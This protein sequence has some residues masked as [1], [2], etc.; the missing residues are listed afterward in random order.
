MLTHQDNLTLLEGL[1]GDK[2]K[3]LPISFRHEGVYLKLSLLLS[4]LINHVFAQRL[5]KRNDS[6]INHALL[7]QLGDLFMTS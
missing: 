1:Q 2:R 3:S 5:K 4:F 6:M 7:A